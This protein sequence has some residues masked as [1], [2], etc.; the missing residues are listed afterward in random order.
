[1]SDK[2]YTEEQ[3][4]DYKRRLGDLFHKCGRNLYFHSSWGIRQ[5]EV[6]KMLM[7]GPMTQ[8]AIQEK[9]GV[10]PASISETITKLEEKKLVVR[11][12]SESDRRIVVIELTEQGR[13]SAE[14]RARETSN[15]TVGIPLEDE[16]IE[17]LLHLLEKLDKGFEDKDKG[18]YKGRL[19]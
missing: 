1:M 7:D 9:M 16:E 17:Q 11:G 3:M 15:F 10:Q 19:V 4:R 12:R 8:K 2:V 18:I 14:R 5:T 6:L 13:E